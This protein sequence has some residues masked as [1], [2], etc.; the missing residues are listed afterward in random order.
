M[1]NKRKP[2][3][4]DYKKCSLNDDIISQQRIKSEGYDVHTEKVIKI[5][6][7]NNDDKRLKT[8]DKITTYPHGAGLGRVCKT[9]PLSKVKK[10]Y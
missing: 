10:I 3:V 9:E 1:C 6:L 2:K 4:I 8:Y 5:A 7:S